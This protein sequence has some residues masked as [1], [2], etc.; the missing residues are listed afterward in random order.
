MARWL[1]KLR[2]SDGAV[3]WEMMM[4]VDNSDGMGARNGWET[5]EFTS[6]GGFVVGG[7]ANKQ[8]GNVPSY[9][10]GGQVDEATPIFQKFS[11]TVAQ[12]EAAIDPSSPPTPEWSFICG[13]GNSG[14]CA[15]IKPMVGSV[16]GIRVYM[17]NGVEK[18]VGAVGTSAAL[19]I[20]NVAD[21]SQAAF[22][23]FDSMDAAGYSFMDVEPTFKDGAL[24]GFG[25]TGLDSDT[26][27]QNTMSCVAAEGCGIIRGHLSLVSADLS[28]QIFNAEFN[29]FTGGVGAYAG[30][31]PLAQTVVITECWGLTTLLDGNG[32][33]TSLV[34]ACGQG[35]EGCSEYLV[36]VD[37]T[38]VTACESDPRRTW[39]GTA[40]KTDLSGN[41]LWYVGYF[42]LLFVNYT[43]QV[44]Q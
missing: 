18:V 15:G 3:I 32:D 16:K 43:F 28:T 20:L 14:N 27:A 9:K 1:V 17:D 35:I 31:T 29:D 24:S 25:V 4:P 44:P 12:S 37:Q 13:D 23:D 5:V 34:A 10:S 21:G 22:K 38:V 40:V 8:S 39:R 30:L 33:T 11:S 42:C 19:L 6:D 26:A 41:I 7:W 36:G 2:A